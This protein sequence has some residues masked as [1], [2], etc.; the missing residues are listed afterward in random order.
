MWERYITDANEA[1]VPETFRASDEAVQQ[2]NQEVC[3]LQGKIQRIEGV[4]TLLKNLIRDMLFDI[5]VIPD[6]HKYVERLQ[7]LTK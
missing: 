7:E 1:S 5:P 2:H 4:N 6:R 3:N